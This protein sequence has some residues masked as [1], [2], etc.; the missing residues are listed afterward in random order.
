MFLKHVRMLSNSS[1]MCGP[2]R[3]E[4]VYKLKM[5]ERVERKGNLLIL[6]VGI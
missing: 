6:L 3:R 2:L 5:L 4:Q 1:V